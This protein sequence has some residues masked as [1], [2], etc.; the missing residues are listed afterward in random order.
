MKWIMRYDLDENLQVILDRIDSKKDLLDSFRPLP[1]V[2]VRKFKENM[3]FEWTYHSNAIEGNTLTLNETRFII[4]EG[5]TINGKPLREHLEAINH[6]DAIVWLE[7]FVSNHEVLRERDILDIHALVMDKIDRQYAGRYRSAGVR[8]TGAN[9]TPPNAHLVAELIEDLIQWSESYKDIHP[10]LKSALFHHRFVWI[11]PFFD[12][13]G[14]TTRLVSNIFMM[15]KGFPPAF[16]L[17]SDRRKYY[18]GLNKA[19]TGIMDKWFLLWLQS[20]ERSLDL[21]LSHLDAERDDYQSLQS[22]VEESAVPYGQE[23]LSLLAR[24][25]KID[26]Y[27]EG[28]VWYSSERA[29]KQYIIGRQRKR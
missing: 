16:I 1:E 2:L 12:G 27:K 29:I 7:D 4:E 5:L 3:S 28:N 17:K 22:I 23:Y 21:Y 14:R 18:D 6:H 15:Q 10:V 24:Q 19:N 25:G 20:V 11:H 9:F 8:I 13:N 26:A